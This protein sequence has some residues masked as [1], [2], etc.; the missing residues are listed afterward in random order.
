MIVAISSSTSCVGSSPVIS[1]SI[2]TRCFLLFFGRAIA[3]IL[4]KLERVQISL[5]AVALTTDILNMFKIIIAGG[6]GH[7]GTLLTRHFRHRRH[8]VI[9]LGRKSAPE[10]WRQI[11]GADAV[12]NLVG[13][14]VDCRY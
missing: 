6:S 12:I 7:L 10:E 14:S 8:N 9:V 13:R 5:D 1:Q 2:Q 11:E 3:R 4:S